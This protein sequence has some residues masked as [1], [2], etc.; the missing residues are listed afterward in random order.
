MIS[1]WIEEKMYE[2]DM[3]FDLLCKCVFKQSW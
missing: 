1:R 3:I 2:I